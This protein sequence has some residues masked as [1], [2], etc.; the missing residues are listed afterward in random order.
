MYVHCS[1][2]H[3]IFN[4]L[5]DPEYSIRLASL[6]EYRESL[7]ARYPP[8]CDNCSPAVEDQIRQKDHMARTKALGA[9]LNDSKGK[10]RQRRVDSEGNREPERATTEV[11]IWRLRGCLWAVTLMAAV[12]CNLAGRGSYTAITTIFYDYP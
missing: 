10:E 2:E 5:Q 9:W 12:L 1:L 8:V 7:H 11:I 4:S 3:L 6:K